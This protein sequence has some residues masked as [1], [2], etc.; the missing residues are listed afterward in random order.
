MGQR[1]LLDR[2]LKEADRSSGVVAAP[3]RPGARSFVSVV[4]RALRCRRCSLMLVGDDGQLVVEE[5]VGL[6][7]GL[8]AH[9]R[10][11]L[12]GSVAGQVIQSGEP[13][14]VNGPIERAGSPDPIGV[15]ASDA[16]ISFPI[17]LPDGT[18][19]VVNV[20]DREDGTPFGP[21]D[22]ALL[23]ELTSFFASTFD[24]PARR[25][26]WRLR[27]ELRRE[28]A[29]SIQREEAERQRLARELHDDAGHA[30]TAAILRLDMAA[31]RLIGRGELTEALDAIR[32]GLV[33]CAEHLHDLAF[34]LQPR[35]LADLGLA[36]ALRS[37]ARRIREVGAV[38][39]DV[40]VDGEER[41]LHTDAEL[42]AFRIAQE[43]ATNSLKHAKA[44]KITF[45]LTFGEDGVTIEICDDG[46]GF[47]LAPSSD[48]SRSRQGLNGMRERAELV[49]GVL[50]ILS[51]SGVGT[52]IRARLPARPPA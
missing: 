13:L 39:V 19:G 36:P 20:T 33:E 27:A 4:A 5:S 29:R 48:G 35:L 24:T 46:T 1:T 25:E 32:G 30:L 17:E 10:A 12:E 18:A 37:L 31:G 26:V 52:T 6:P 9:A 23:A 42:A 7:A 14:V 21:D 16:F 11:P 40:T 2:P 43:A 38:E 47:V 41:R 28:R 50:E 34:R 44:G 45:A 15:Y 8:D 22:L 3:E 49:S 51:R